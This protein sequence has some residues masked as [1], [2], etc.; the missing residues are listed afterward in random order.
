VRRIWSFFSF[1]SF[2][3][4]YICKTNYK[5]TLP[6]FSLFS[7]FF[8]FP[9]LYYLHTSTRPSVHPTKRRRAAGMSATPATRTEEEDEDEDGDDE[10]LPLER[11]AAATRTLESAAAPAP[12]AAPP[13]GGSAASHAPP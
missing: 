6:L 11:D 9:S 8:L 3:F 10:E 4:F 13:E 7:L 5:K 1:R 12:A 2:L